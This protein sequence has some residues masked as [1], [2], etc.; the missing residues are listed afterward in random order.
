MAGLSA[1]WAMHRPVI[2]PTVAWLSIGGHRHHVELQA[3]HL[4]QPR[5]QRAAAGDHAEPAAL[6]PLQGRVLGQLVLGQGDLGVAEQGQR[7]LQRRPG[8]VVGEGQRPGV[9]VVVEEVAAAR[10]DERRQP[11]Q[12]GRDRDALGAAGRA[13]RERRRGRELVEVPAPVVGRHVEAA[14]GHP[15]EVDQRGV[16]EHHLGSDAVRHALEAVVAAERGQRV[17]GVDVA[18][19]DAALVEQAVDGPG[20][21]VL[22]VPAQVAPGHQEGVGKRLTLGDRLAQ[23]AVAVPGLHL[24]LGRL[25]DRVEALGHPGVGG[26]LVGR[27]VDAERQVDRRAGGVGGR[28]AGLGGPGSTTSC[29]RCRPASAATRTRQQPSAR[30]TADL[31]VILLARPAP[32][33]RGPH[34]SGPGVGPA[35]TIST[36]R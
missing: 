32:G 18:E 33:P 13:R 14:E 29:H 15:I 35:R 8:P 27:A 2:S 1:S 12:G 21:L 5:D 9:L 28:A 17:A 30:A 19:V 6:E 25:V 22:G 3:S 11:A 36:G 23:A 7:G 20:E 26:D 24:D 31:T 16:V 10:V 4:A 34:C